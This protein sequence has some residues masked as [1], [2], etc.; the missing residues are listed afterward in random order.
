M[1]LI[2]LMILV[3]AGAATIFTLGQIGLI[4][5]GRRPADPFASALTSALSGAAALGLSRRDPSDHDLLL[6]GAGV[7][8]VVSIAGFV[9]GRRT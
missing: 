3:V 1:H 4:Q 6:F 2:S 5:A 9:V 7:A 8:I